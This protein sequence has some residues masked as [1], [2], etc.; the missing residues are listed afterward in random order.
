METKKNS[1]I[2]IT[3]LIFGIISVLLSCILVGG[4]TGIIGVVLCI[5][6]LIDKNAKKGFAIAGLILNTFA[7]VIVIIVLLV[8]VSEKGKTEKTS[9]D[10]A[11]DYSESYVS[12]EHNENDG[13]A[14]IEKFNEIKTGMTYDEV[15]EIMGSEGTVVSE[16]GMDGIVTTIYCWKSMFGVA[17]MNVT[18]TN[19]KVLAKAQFGLD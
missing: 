1:A 11:S 7:I 2:G 4:F 19:G 6:S 16:A 8:S 10:Q 5:L 9:G 15:V 14:T 18:I 13:Y 12:E 3:G 17:N